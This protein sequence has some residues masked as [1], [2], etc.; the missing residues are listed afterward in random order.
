MEIE[1]LDNGEN[2]LLLPQ[3][4]KNVEHKKRGSLVFL[5]WL[6]KI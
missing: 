1:T 5:K 4:S 2:I 3:K 6:V